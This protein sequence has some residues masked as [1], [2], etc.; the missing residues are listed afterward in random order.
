MH[1]NKI[2]NHRQ[3]N[4]KEREV[5]EENGSFRI[6]FGDHGVGGQQAAPVTPVVPKG[7]QQTEANLGC[8]ECVLK[9]YKKF[10]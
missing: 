4:Q 8:I 1:Q 10:K 6:V 5:I 3:K 9:F 2:A 7:N